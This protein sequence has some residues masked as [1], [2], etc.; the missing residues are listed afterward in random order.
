MTS[1]SRLDSVWFDR[2]DM[3]HSRKR[4]GDENLF[5]VV[6]VLLAYATESYSLA[7][8]LSYASDWL[9]QCHGRCADIHRADVS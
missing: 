8:P 4:V 3:A 2:R 6:A 7:C 5:F 9:A 1:T